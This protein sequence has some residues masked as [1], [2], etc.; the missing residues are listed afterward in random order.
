MDVNVKHN[1]FSTRMGNTID[2]DRK[3]MDKYINFLIHLDS[4]KGHKA[5]LSNLTDKQKKENGVKYQKQLDKY[6]EKIKAD[7][8]TKSSDLIKFAKSKGVNHLVLENLESSK[9]SD[10]KDTETGF[11]YS[12]L[13]KEVGLVNIKNVVKGIAY[14]NGVT[15]SLGH[16]HYTS[17]ECRCCG[18]I[19]KNNRKTQETFTCTRCGHTGEADLESPYNIEK[20]VSSDVLREK[21][22]KQNKFGELIPRKLSKE[23]IRE[24]LETHSAGLEAERSKVS[25]H[26]LGEVLV[27]H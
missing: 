7:V 22:L 11:K 25:E 4:V 6:K 14:K 18:N 10:I 3:L 13:F 5:K 23:Y 21:L 26:K 24:V 12:R 16:P 19:D 17:Q 27:L 9:S 1:M 8:Q 15:V 20:R 2:Y